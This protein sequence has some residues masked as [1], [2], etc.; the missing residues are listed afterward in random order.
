MR[1]AGERNLIL[2]VSL[3]L[4]LG[5]QQGKAGGCKGGGLPGFTSGTLPSV[6][7]FGQVT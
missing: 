2:R 5:F 1:G 7:D 6:C 4:L 3:R